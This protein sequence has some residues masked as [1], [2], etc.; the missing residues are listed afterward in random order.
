MRSPAD[1]DTVRAMAAA[2]VIAPIS[3]RV[4]LADAAAAL[5]L[6]ALALGDTIASHHDA[7]KAAVAAIGLAMTAPLAWRRRAPLAVLLT[8]LGAVM[9]LGLADG[10]ANELYVLLATL[11]ATYSVGA[12]ADR[13]TA[14]AGLAAALTVMLLGLWFDGHESGDYLFVAV[15]YAGGW[16]LGASLRE[17]THRARRLEGH[18][19]LLE[20]ER[21]RKAREAVLEERARI[22]RELHDVVAH[23]VSVM[24]V[25]NGVVRRRIGAER[26]EEAGMLEESEQTG[27][28]A[29]AEM[30]RLLG[31]LRTE[32]EQ[33]DLAPQPGMDSLPAL[34]EQV[35]DA[36]LPV[37][38][39][40][41]G[42]ERPLPPGLDLAAYRIVQEALTNALKHAGGA[43]TRVCVRYGPRRLALEV[44]D[45]GPGATATDGNGHG[46][47]GMRER[48]SLYGGTLT[49]G[50]RDG[51]GFSVRRAA[52]RGLVTIRVVVADDQA[53][54]RRGF[55]APARR[56]A[57]HAGG[58]RGRRRRAGGR[59]RREAP[60]GRVPDGHPDAGVDG[61]EATRRIVA[62]DLPTR[63]LM[64]T[65]FD[66]DEYVYGASARGRAAF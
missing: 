34:V 39:R 52:A 46:L 55:A 16:A 50:A 43:A 45:D 59:G 38:L 53:M 22:A 48:A 61:L 49:A 17:R 26:S 29:L 6:V 41:E 28:Q 51:G 24:V 58:R 9:A 31:L 63:V 19:A 42:D 33:L 20:R 2:A 4:P 13:R 21:E 56:R 40:V 47:V 18:A 37:E 15:L 14:A 54:V 62:S 8:S 30:R 65:T 44:D 35:R 64:L 32:D 25:Q 60:A 3:R 27:R 10:N 12:N 36:G 57:R 23:S 66:L 1:R 5:G 11:L 7:P